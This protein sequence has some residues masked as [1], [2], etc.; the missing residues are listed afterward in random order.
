MNSNKL[1]EKDEK[2]EVVSCRERKSPAPVAKG[3]I[4]NAI[5]WFYAIH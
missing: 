5:P 3:Q 4:P 2:A 1:L